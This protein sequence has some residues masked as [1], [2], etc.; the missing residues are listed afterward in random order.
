MPRYIRNRFL[1]LAGL[2]LFGLICT[3]PSFKSDLPGWMQKIRISEGMRLGL[4]LQGGMHLILKV[5]VARAVQHQTQT[6]LAGPAESLHK[7]HLLV[8]AP[9]MTA[10]GR[11]R[12]SLGNVEA[13]RSARQTLKEQ[14]PNLEI[15][16]E[17]AGFLELSLKAND[18]A[19]F[20]ANAVDQSLEIIR[21]RIDQFGVEEPVIVRQG[22]DQI[23][24]Q[25]AGVKDPERAMEIVGRTAQLEFR[26]VATSPGAELAARFEAALHTGRLKPDFSHQDLNRVLKDAIAQGNELYIEKRV[27]RQS[28]GVRVFPVLLE[29]AVLM[30]GEALKTARTEIGGKFGEPYVSLTF[31]ARGARLFEEITRKGVG[32]QL[33]IVL[34]DI[35]QS[36]PVIQERISGGQAQITGCFTAEEAQDLAIVLR[37]GALPA[38]VE[39]VQNMTVGP[40]LGLD[41]IRKGLAATAWAPCW[42]CSSWSSTTGFRERSPTW[43]CC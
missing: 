16:S 43:P 36:A 32:R 34:D 4:D 42:W 31:N 33:A 17:G 18:I 39:V 15:A 5:D 11:I 2:T 3:L 6:A 29:K 24:L 14:F 37:A 20:E 13:V 28:G 19:A 41:S 40:S 25:L 22:R 21:N 10:G 26:M 9:E 27:D 1:I 7:Q 23:V 8:R 38:P 35:V 30:T 12:L